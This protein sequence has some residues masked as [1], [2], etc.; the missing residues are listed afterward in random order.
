MIADFPSGR[1]GGV[2][3]IYILEGVCVSNTCIL[4]IFDEILEAYCTCTDTFVSGG[5]WMAV[6]V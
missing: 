6:S 2:D 3:A 4:G 1:K 5:G